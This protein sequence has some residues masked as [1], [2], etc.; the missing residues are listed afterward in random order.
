MG[1]PNIFSKEQIKF[2]GENYKDKTSQELANLVNQK[3][4]TSFNQKQIL[5]LK[6]RHK[7]NTG[8]N[9]KFKKGSI[10]H[11]K[12][13]K[14]SIEAYKKVLPHLWKDGH[15]VWK[16]RP[17]G[18]E[19]LNKDNMFEVKVIVK[20]YPN[21]CYCKN[22]DGTGWIYKQIKTWLDKGRELPKGHKICLLNQNKTD[23][24]IENLVCLSNKELRWLNAHYGWTKESEVNQ[25]KINIVKL[26]CKLKN[27]ESKK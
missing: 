14:M 7:W 22:K 6:C 27:I 21:N 16:A 18:S 10:S 19:R 20:D 4:G 13:K 24:S 17:I 15:K 26:K 2:V 23:F 5:G 25:A 8:L 11:N 9:M 12:G 1:T 3:F